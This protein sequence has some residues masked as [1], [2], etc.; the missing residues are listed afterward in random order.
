MSRSGE[1][2]GAGVVRAN[3]ISWDGGGLGTDVD[4][5]TDALKRI[6]CTVAFK[7]RKYRRP[8]NRA[9]SVAM[10]VRATVA[11]KWAALTGNPAFDINFFVESIFPEFLPVG[12]VNCLFPNPEWFREENVAHLPALDWVLCKTPSAVTAFE[13]LPVPARLIGFSSPDKLI[14]PRIRS[15]PL[16][17]LHV[18]G[19]SAL[20]GTA[21]VV[22]VWSHHPEWPELTVVRNARRYGG[23]PAPALPTRA[24]IKFEMEHLDDARL[25][26]LQNECV[27]HVI[28]SEAEGYGHLLAEGMSCGAVVVTTDAPPMNELVGRDRGILVSV[29]RSEPMRLG[30]RNFVDVVDLERQLDAVFAM[31]WSAMDALGRNARRWYESQSGH[32]EES[33]REFLAEVLPTP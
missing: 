27:V 22:E 16:R 8:S 19:A 21:A 28:P 3:I 32:F 7:G 15:G 18:A 6:G 24:N 31:E 33:L 14:T 11:Q 29:A 17:C 20:K 30:V 25:R 23:D 13:H 10:T 26:Q 5:L 9:H 1:V 4:V 12:K 2:R